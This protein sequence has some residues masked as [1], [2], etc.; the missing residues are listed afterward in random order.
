M[1][2]TTASRPAIASP[3]VNICVIHPGARICVGCYRTGDEIARWTRYTDAERAA[4]MAVLPERAGRLTD[5]AAR[6]STRLRGRD[7]A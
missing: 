1:T 2:D 3:C 5:V 4:L 7:P 6:P